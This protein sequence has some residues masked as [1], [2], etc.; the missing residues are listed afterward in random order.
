MTIIKSITHS[1]SLLQQISGHQKLANDPELTD[2]LNSLSV[3]LETITLAASQLLEE[4]ASI[5]GSVI[6]NT[7]PKMKSGC[8]IFA[9][10]KGFFCPHCYDNTGHKIPTKRMNSKLRVCPSCRSSIS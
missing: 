1:K 3:E 8:Y 7:K 2:L 4:Q 6:S 10:Q 9:D 5:Q